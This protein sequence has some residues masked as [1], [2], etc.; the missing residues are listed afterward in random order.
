V[1]VGKLTKTD[2]E[3]WQSLYRGYADF[4][5]MPMNEDILKSVW[6]W[7]FDSNIKFYAIGVKTSEGKLIGL[8]HYREMPSPLRGSLV[9]FLDDLYIHPDHR[10]TGAVQLLFKELKGIARQNSWPYV[11]WIT[12]TDN[13]RARA[14]YDKISETIDFVTYQMPSH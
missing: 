9:G 2:Q 3:D 6:L 5:H 8:M 13:H 7:I 14:V 10:G 4:Y 1:K 12:A 11:R